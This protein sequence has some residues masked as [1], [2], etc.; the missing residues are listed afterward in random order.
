MIAIDLITD[1]VPP[2][3]A[4]ES[5]EKTLR[6][7]D[8]FKVSHI[9]VIEGNNYIG[10]ASDSMLLDM[11]QP[12]SSLKEAPLNLVKPFVRDN[13][14][15]YEVMQ[16]VS[17]LNLTVVPVLDA[18]D[19]YV[20]LTTLPRLMNLITNTVSVSEK[21]S[22]VILEL[23]QHDYS[24]AQIAQIIEGNDAK[25]LSIFTTSS[26]DSTEL[27]VTIKINKQN[28]DGI[29]QTFHRY[30]YTVRASYQ[31]SKTEDD[32]RNRYEELMHYLKM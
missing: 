3:K 6:W 25:V 9:P 31:E 13:Q 30:D 5:V 21:G 14:H 18:E 20:G 24:F 7:M 22:T 10:L 11:S 23:N 32:V 12:N 4:S 16:L 8:E 17:T 2:I 19:R 27:E 1:T 28:I 26:S 29:L 15:I